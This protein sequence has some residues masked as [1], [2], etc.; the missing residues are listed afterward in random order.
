MV[1]SFK[2]PDAAGRRT[3]GAAAPTFGSSPEVWMG[4]PLRVIWAMA[5]S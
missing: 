3:P 5:R 2:G 1:A 4:L